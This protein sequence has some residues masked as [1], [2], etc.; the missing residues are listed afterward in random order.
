MPLDARPVSRL[1]AA[2]LTCAA[3]GPALAGGEQDQYEEKMLARGVERAMRVAKSDRVLWVKEL[4]EAFPDK[5][6]DPLKEEDYAAWFVLL[7]GE[8]S[9]WR[10][11]TA[12]TPRIAELYDR[13]LQR[14]E[15]GPV[16]SLKREEFMRYARRSLVQGN[17]NAGESDQYEDPDRV[18]RVLDRDGDGKLEPE[19]MTTKL[20]EEKPRADSDGNGR[21]DKDEYRAYFRARVVVNTDLAIKAAEQRGERGPDGKPLSAPTPAPG[22]AP[23]WFAGFDTDK[24]NQISLAE[25][26]KAGRDIAA[27][28]EMDLDGD[29]LLTKEEHARF[30]VLKEKAAAAAKEAEKKEEKR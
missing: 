6:G 9:E 12:P 17:P 26:R 16:P 21:I 11:E 15:L 4:S 24:D 7:A 5:V 3:P 13:A 10:R 20:R 30:T 23:A 29:G 1:L 18:F 25:W 8:A 28:M 2:L 27:F 14:L 22:A 19:E